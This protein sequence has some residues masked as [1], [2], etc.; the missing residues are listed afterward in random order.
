MLAVQGV[1]LG[2]GCKVS[3]RRYGYYA[4][5]QRQAE[6]FK[7]KAQREAQPAAGAFAG[8]HYAVVAVAPA[9]KVAVSLHSIL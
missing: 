7:L 5:G 2:S 8:K 4:R 3:P 6:A 1:G 9:Y